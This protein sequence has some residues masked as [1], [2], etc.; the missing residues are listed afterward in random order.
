MI[1]DNLSEYSRPVKKVYAFEYVAAAEVMKDVGLPNIPF[2]Y[3][4]ELPDRPDAVDLSIMYPYGYE[5]PRYQTFRDLAIKAS[6]HSLSLSGEG[7]A[8]D[9]PVFAQRLHDML[10]TD[11]QGMRTRR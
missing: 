5:D 7:V 9:D 4:V 6:K 2:V 3:V 10:L 8:I 11:A 1:K